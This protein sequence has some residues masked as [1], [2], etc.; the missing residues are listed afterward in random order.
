[1]GPAKSRGVAT[2]AMVMRLLELFD[3]TGFRRPHRG[4]PSDQGRGRS[5]PGLDPR[6]GRHA[7]VSRMDLGELGWCAPAQASASAACSGRRK[8]GLQASSRKPNTGT[9][10]PASMVVVTAK[11]KSFPASAKPPVQKRAGPSETSTRALRRPGPESELETC[12]QA[13][14]AAVLGF[15]LSALSR[16]SG[17][18]ASDAPASRGSCGRIILVQFTITCLCNRSLRLLFV[19]APGRWLFL[20]HDDEAAVTANA[21]KFHW[22]IED[23]AAMEGDE[24]TRRS[25]FETAFERLAACCRWTRWTPRP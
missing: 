10:M 2:T 8:H 12:P 4:R 24:E 21:I 6:A 14:S 11:P 5:R 9:R 22:D 13:G 16:L 19:S 15:V 18:D 17:A 3:R 25:A 20:R 23:P 7:P 1:M